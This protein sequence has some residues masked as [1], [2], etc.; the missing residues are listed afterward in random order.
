MF[1]HDQPVNAD[2]W[3]GM[4]PIWRWEEI[5]RVWPS[6][7]RPPL[8]LPQLGAPYTHGGVKAEAPRWHCATPS[9]GG[10]GPLRSLHHCPQ[11][12]VRQVGTYVEQI[13]DRSVVNL[14]NFLNG[15]FNYWWYT[16]RVLP[17]NCAVPQSDRLLFQCFP[18]EPSQWSDERSWTSYLFWTWSLIKVVWWESAD[19]KS[20]LHLA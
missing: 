1:S 5:S 17:E 7:W 9:E 3:D 20:G 8:A 2:W 18:L 13:V 15:T 6:F 12:R 16:T 19:G 4:W 10:A 11:T 14:C